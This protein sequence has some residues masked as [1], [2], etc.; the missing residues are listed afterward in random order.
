MGKK[1]ISKRRKYLLRVC[2]KENRIFSFARLLSHRHEVRACRAS[3][4]LSNMQ[5]VP[6]DDFRVG[7]I[8]LHFRYHQ[9]FSNLEL[10]CPR[11][12]RRYIQNWHQREETIS[13]N[14]RN[15]PRQHQISDVIYF[16]N[17]CTLYDAHVCV[18]YLEYSTRSA[19]AML[20]GESWRIIKGPYIIF[21]CA[22][23]GRA[24]GL[25]SQGRGGDV[26]EK[27]GWR[28]ILTGGRRR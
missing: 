15:T 13:R 10:K 16:L 1:R 11:M 9:L 21:R 6:E 18:K 23:A 26:G 5:F 28:S 14:S 7:V 20:K 8:F 27:R 25:N 17:L 24:R 4:E 12:F 3:R 2:L 22:T 19:W